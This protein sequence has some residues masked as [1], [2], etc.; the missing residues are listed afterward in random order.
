[1]IMDHVAL[2]VGR[3]L[4]VVPDQEVPDQRRGVGAG[5]VPQRLRDHVPLQLRE[6]AAWRPGDTLPE[7]A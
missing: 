7:V 4:P 6:V 2:D 1:M 3:R 5:R